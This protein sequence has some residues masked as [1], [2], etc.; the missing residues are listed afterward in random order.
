M[1]TITANYPTGRRVGGENSSFESLVPATMLTELARI[2]QMFPFPPVIS[3]YSE[4]SE[5]WEFIRRHRPAL[6]PE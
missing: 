3:E 6:F 5:H 4:Y 2:A 1:T